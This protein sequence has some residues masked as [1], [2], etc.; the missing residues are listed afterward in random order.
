M[1]LCQDRGIQKRYFW[2]NEWFKAI[3]DQ[4][5]NIL[6]CSERKSSIKPRDGNCW[7]IR[8]IT[9]KFAYK[10]DEVVKFD[11]SSLS[12]VQANIMQE[13]F[14]EF[15]LVLRRQNVYPGKPGAYINL[16][17]L[18]WVLNL[19]AKIKFSCFSQPS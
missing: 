14:K 4:L 18:Q 7:L 2:I 11:V 10:R 13:F 9:Q 12:F 19:K 1:L 3:I 5:K 6:L 17:M 16:W 15:Q 8:D